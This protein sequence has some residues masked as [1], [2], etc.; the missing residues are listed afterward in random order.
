[1]PQ[2]VVTPQGIMPGQQSCHRQWCHF[3]LRGLVFSSAV[4]DKFLSHPFG[5]GH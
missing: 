3:G 1:M 2:W 4:H 5:E